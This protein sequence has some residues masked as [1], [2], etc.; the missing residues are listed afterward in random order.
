M[1]TQKK[2]EDELDFLKDAIR[3]EHHPDELLLT[4]TL[5]LLHST[6]TDIKRIADALEVIAYPSVKV[7]LGEQEP[8][9]L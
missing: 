1:T 2:M 5:A 6:L 3:E 7:P 9:V 4:C 8:D